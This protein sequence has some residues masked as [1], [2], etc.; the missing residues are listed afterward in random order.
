MHSPTSHVRIYDYLLSSS[1]PDHAIVTDIY[2]TSIVYFTSSAESHK[3]LCH[4]GT[5]CA[6]MDDVIGWTGFC[7]SGQCIPWSGYTV[8]V[9]TTLKKPIPIGSILRIEGWIEK[10]EGKRKIHIR[11]KLTDEH[12]DIHAIGTGLFLKK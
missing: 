7:E 6:I 4:G 11:A 9:D 2:L 1:H 5:M 8:Q 12:G 10:R 3:G